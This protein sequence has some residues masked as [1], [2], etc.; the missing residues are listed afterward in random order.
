ML[1][2]LPEPDV[3]LKVLAKLG[4]PDL[5]V[6]A[7]INRAARQL[8]ERCMHSS[9]QL[10]ARFLAAHPMMSYHRQ[11]SMSPWLN[12]PKE[13]SR[14]VAHDMAPSGARAA[15]LLKTKP[16]SKAVDAKGA[17]NLLSC[18]RAVARNG[19]AATSDVGCRQ[20]EAVRHLLGV[21]SAGPWSGY[22]HLWH[23]VVETALEEADAGFL[24]E[25]LAAAQ[26]REKEWASLRADLGSLLRAAIKK[27]NERA[28]R[29]A[30]RK[31]LPVLLPY[32][33]ANYEIDD[34]PADAL[35]K[36]VRK[37]LAGA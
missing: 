29:P 26:A 32:L 17:Q 35:V 9:V 28:W 37:Q 22:S 13:G 14:I 21:F 3:V 25:V 33:D 16:L 36:R 7:C 27:W 31:V 10:T 6:L 8:V 4:G 11:G 1:R 2:V 5:A 18:V 34:G 19:R 20:R 30:L 12:V 15:E 23:E 24:D